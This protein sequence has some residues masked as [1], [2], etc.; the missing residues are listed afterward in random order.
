MKN[1]HDKILVG[2]L[3]ARRLQQD[4]LTDLLKIGV[5]TQIRDQTCKVASL[6]ILHF[7]GQWSNELAQ[8]N[9]A[10]WSADKVDN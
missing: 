7:I 1:F 8:T 4:W 2:I 9:M 3:S 10:D 6:Q 5:D